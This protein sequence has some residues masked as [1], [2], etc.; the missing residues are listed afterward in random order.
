VLV[1]IHQPMY[2]PWLPFFDKVVRSN[3]FVVFDTAQFERGEYIN[4][5]Y[6]KTANGATLLTVPVAG[7]RER[8]IIETLIRA[9]PGRWDWRRKHVETIRQAYA[10]APRFAELM[11][12]LQALYAGEYRTICE[13]NLV[14]L[15]F[16]LSWFGVKRRIERAS[17]LRDLEGAEQT[18]LGLC[19]A[20]GAD[21]YL[22]GPMGE[23]YLDE[24][25]FD[26]AGITVLYQQFKLPVY[27]QLHGE[28][29]AGMGI[30][31]FAMMGGEL[32]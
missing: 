26:S 5:Q 27:P 14:Q 9:A 4:R 25:P 19:K 17:M 16:W 28:F 8:P 12:H 29:E 31:D 20:V 32:V 2:L 22:S 18:N 11:P 30:V 10:R 21:T 23:G 3:V 1:S 24:Q 7:G 13:L 15:Q 6:V